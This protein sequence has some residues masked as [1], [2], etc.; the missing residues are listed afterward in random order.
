MNSPTTA[1]LLPRDF[2]A[3][4][5]QVCK[6]IFICSVNISNGNLVA[7]IEAFMQSYMVFSHAKR[8]S[9]SC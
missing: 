3:R 4:I 1:I 6:E 7:S 5:V 2:G 9:K 8:Q